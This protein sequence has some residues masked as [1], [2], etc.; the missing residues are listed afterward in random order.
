MNS[1]AQRDPR[2]DPA[3][4][5]VVRGPGPRGRHRTIHC[6]YTNGKFGWA[7][8]CPLASGIITLAAW[9]KWAHGGETICR[10]QGRGIAGA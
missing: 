7:T 6:E 5:D 10:L 8:E 3:I 2:I 4:G 9:R 1:Q